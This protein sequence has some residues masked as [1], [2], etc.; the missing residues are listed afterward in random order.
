[1]LFVIFGKNFGSWRDPGRYCLGGGGGGVDDNKLLRRS[2]WG[3]DARGRLAA[4][5]IENIEFQQ[6]GKKPCRPI[7]YYRKLK[8]GYKYGK[9]F[10]YKSDQSLPNNFSFPAIL[11]FRDFYT[12][13][14]DRICDNVISPR[15]LTNLLLSFTGQ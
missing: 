3:F 4:P 10:S 14:E 1:M 8:F 9:Y 12:D 15:L 5:R 11:L 2:P 7:F 6:T 13:R